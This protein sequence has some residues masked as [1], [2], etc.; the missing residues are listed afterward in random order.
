MKNYG[1][2]ARTFTALQYI[3]NLET[4]RSP[5]TTLNLENIILKKNSIEWFKNY[6]L[7]CSSR[8]KCLQ[9]PSAN[10]SASIHAKQIL[11]SSNRLELSPWSFTHVFN[12]IEATIL[13]EIACQKRFVLQLT[14]KIQ[15]CPFYCISNHNNFILKYLDNA[16]TDSRTSRRLFWLWR[17]MYRSNRSFNI[18]PPL[19]RAYL[20]HL[21]P[22]PSRGSLFQAPR[23][24]WKVVQ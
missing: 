9:K 8:K 23:W 3:N 11:C 15:D 22:L 24:W 18:P 4:Q 1:I 5:K 2:V 13:R 10:K 6:S 16:L 21:T 7:I 12:R 14:A 17:L 19:P 20:G